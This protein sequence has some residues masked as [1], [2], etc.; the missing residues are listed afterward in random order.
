MTTHVLRPVQ[1]LRAYALAAI[2]STVGALV[3]VAGNI[4]ASIWIVALGA[5]ILSGGL[6]LLGATVNSVRRYKVSVDLDD[7]GYAIHASTGDHTGAW[8]DVRRV[9]RT[10]DGTQLT[11]HHDGDRRTLLVGRDVTTLEAD[12]AHYLDKSRGYGSAR[13]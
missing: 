9:T 3:L 4:S 6:V 10:A 12:M 5:L 11:L 1:P 7:Q 13:R 8:A 2:L